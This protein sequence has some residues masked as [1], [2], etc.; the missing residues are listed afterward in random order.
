M[1]A[2]VTDIFQNSQS[3]YSISSRFTDDLAQFRRPILGVGHF[4]QTVTVLRDACT[5]LH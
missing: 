3:K 2:T 5:E 4:R 1:K